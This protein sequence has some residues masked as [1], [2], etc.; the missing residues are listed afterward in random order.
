MSGNALTEIVIVKNRKRALVRFPRFGVLFVVFVAAFPRFGSAQT[1][2]LPPNPIT[3]PTVSPPTMESPP[4]VEAP[5]VTAPELS[6]TTP[7]ATNA[8]STTSSSSATPTPSASA[9]SLL[10][11]GSDNALLRALSGNDTSASGLD[12]FSGLLGTNAGRSSTDSAVLAKV[13]DLLQERQG[14]AGTTASPKAPNPDAKK[15][16]MPQTAAM[17]GTVSSGGVLV[18]FTINGYNLVPTIT[19]LVSSILA[20]DGSF[21]LTGDRAYIASGRTRA[22]TFYFLCRKNDGGSYRLRADVSQDFINEYS[23]LY[24][25]ARRSPLTGTLTGDLL[26]FRVSEPAWNSDIVIRVISPTVNRDSDR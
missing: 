5:T 15:G 20:R 6:A 25:L 1:G 22:E 9:L 12:A 18:R 7:N 17:N 10:G 26:V 23:Y 2:Y 24:Q 8:A 13:L 11:L 19:T 3:P 21:L 4:T 16:T 14:Q